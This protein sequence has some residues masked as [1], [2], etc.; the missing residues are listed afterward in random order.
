MVDLECFGNLSILENT[1]GIAVDPTDSPVSVMFADHVG[2][3]G[4]REWLQCFLD[5]GSVALI[6][7]TA[8][9]VVRVNDCPVLSVFDVASTMPAKR[10]EIPPVA[11]RFLS[12]V[13]QVEVAKFIA[14]VFSFRPFG[15]CPF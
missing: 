6:E 5:D 14:H 15:W 12:G 11:R 2:I 3:V 8:V 4:V 1:D 13:I 9:S 10:V 7:K